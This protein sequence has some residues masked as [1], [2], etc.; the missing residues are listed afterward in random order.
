M[1]EKNRANDCWDEIIEYITEKPS[2]SRVKEEKP[3]G[4]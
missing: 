1:L 3:Y 2:M 4:G